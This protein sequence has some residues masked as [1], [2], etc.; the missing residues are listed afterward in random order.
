[1]LHLYVTL[2]VAQT[3]LFDRLTDPSRRQRTELDREAGG[4]T[5]EFVSWA[6]ALLVVAG[7]VIAVVTQYAES[8]SAKII[9][10]N[11]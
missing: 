4:I 9:S 8:E 3:M 1:M 6:V 2:Q 5:L 7:I 10:P 11:P